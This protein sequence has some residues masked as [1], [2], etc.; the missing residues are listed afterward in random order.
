[1]RVSRPG[2]VTLNGLGTVLAAAL[3]VLLFVRPESAEA[4]AC[5]PLPEARTIEASLNRFWGIS[6]RLCQA[7]GFILEAAANPD[8]GMIHANRRWLIAMGRQHG[9]WAVAGILAHEWGHM[10]QNRPQ[11]T[12]AELQADCLAGAFLRAGGFNETDAIRFADL[13]FQ[14]GDL[15]L[16]AFGHGTGIQR[17][18]AV[19]QGYRDFD[20]RRGRS[21]DRV[22]PFGVT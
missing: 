4:K 19:L 1:M 11:G 14:N 17:E 12:A 3:A 22:C 6:A 15:E 13:S 8:Q 21:L 16:S 5:R 18:K 10:V 2:T 7:D 20:D 9:N